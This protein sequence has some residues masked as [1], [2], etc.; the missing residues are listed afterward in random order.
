ML[1]GAVHLHFLLRRQGLL[2]GL[3]HRAHAV[4]DAAADATIALAHV[5]HDGTDQRHHQQHR[6]GYLDAHL[7]HHRQHRDDGEGIGHHGLQRVGAGL[8]D[9][10]GIEVQA[11][12][13][14]RRCFG[15]EVRRRQVQ[16]LLQHLLTQVADHAAA[17][18]GQRIVADPGGH[19][20]HQEQAEDGQR[21]DHGR[22]RL[23]IDKPLVDQRLHQLG[24]VIAGQGFDHHGDDRAHHEHPVGAGV[25]Q[26]T[27]VDRPHRRVM[28][29]HGRTSGAVAMAIRR[30][31]S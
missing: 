25:A 5:G 26:Q 14:H 7:Q 22:A 21:Q 19:A 23:R 2:G 6:Q 29:T 4:L 11:A 24:E 12:D 16:V 9:L 8:G 27:F 20:A 17:G 15:V 30:K 3:R 18:L 13:H 1:L 31:P 28:G 10:L